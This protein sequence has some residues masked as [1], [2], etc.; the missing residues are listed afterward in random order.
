MPRKVVSYVE[1]AALVG[2]LRGYPARVAFHLYLHF[3]GASMLDG[4]VE[5]LLSDAVDVL[6]CFQRGF[7]PLAEGGCDLD[8]VP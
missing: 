5:G 7:R 2:E 1:T 4:V 3:V 6:S 8:P